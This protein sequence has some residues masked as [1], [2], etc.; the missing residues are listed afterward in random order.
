MRMLLALAFVPVGT[1][2]RTFELLFDN[3]SFPDEPQE[4]IDY[5]EDTWNGR[6]KRRN[7]RHPHLFPL[8]LRNMYLSVRDDL[9]KTNNSIEEWF[10]AFETQIES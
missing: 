3:N 5:F 7:V 9:S 6:P 10:H 4:I 2:P 8:N 1:V